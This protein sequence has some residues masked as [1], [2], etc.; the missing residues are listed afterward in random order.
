MPLN[1]GEYDDALRPFHEAMRY[2]LSNSKRYAGT[3]AWEGVPI[4]DLIEGLHKEVAELE[5]AY[6]L[7]TPIEVVLEAV[8][9]ANFAMMIAD[10]FGMRHIKEPVEPEKEDTLA[11]HAGGSPRMEVHVS[12]GIGGNRERG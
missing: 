11:K 12:G 6:N 9:V 5:E 2:K 3:R 7:G 4:K 8:D 10:R 1:R